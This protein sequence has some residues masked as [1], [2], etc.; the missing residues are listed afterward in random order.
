[1]KLKKARVTNFK[2]IIDSTDV[3]LDNI[4]C[5][6]GKNEA[7]K[8]A[9]LRALEG[10]RPINEQFTYSILD[11][12]PRQYRS[13][14]RSRYKDKDAQV[15][16][17][18]WE[19]EK[20][21]HLALAE[22]FGEEAIK[23]NE[24]ILSKNYNQSNYSGKIQIEHKA[25]LKYLCDRFNLTDI[26]AKVIEK[27]ETT[28]IAFDNLLKLKKPSA[29]QQKLLE[30]L[31]LY[32]ANCATLKAVD[33]LSQRVPYFIYISDYAI[34]SD[35]ISF[36]QIRH[37]IQGNINRSDQ[38]FLNLLE[39]GGTNIDELEQI[40]TSKELNA[41][42]ETI[43][44]VITSKVFGYWSLNNTLEFKLKVTT[45]WLNDPAPFGKGV[46]ACAYIVDKNNNIELILSERSAGFIWFFTILVRIAQY[47]EDTILLMDE[48]GLTI[49][50][51]AQKDL[52][53]YFEE[54]I[55]PKQQLVYTTHSPFMVPAN[56]FSR[57]RTVEFVETKEM[58]DGSVI[59][60]TRVS[61]G[62]S[63]G[64]STVNLPIL[65]ALGI[66]LTQNFFVGRN[67][68]L[69]EGASD[70]YYL[71]AFSKHLRTH[72]RQGLDPRWAICPIGGITKFSVFISLFKGNSLNT[73]VVAD[74]EP[75]QKQILDTLYKQMDGDKTRVILVTDIVG[76]READIEDLFEPKFYFKL[77]NDSY[78]FDEKKALGD[79][80]M[81]SNGRRITKIV[82]GHFD[83]ISL[84]YSHEKPSR[85][86]L[87]NAELLK[88]ETEEVSKTVNRFEILFTKVA[89]LIADTSI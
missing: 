30:H 44:D 66:E 5:L 47:G 52:L 9:F 50:G 1:M 72:N 69:V 80:H 68:L 45:G 26:E 37:D 76:K 59:E 33:I 67:T 85:Y 7:G 14:Y 79:I 46:I 16:V 32:R 17:T 83:S 75:K 18:V 73:V 11:D 22:E 62:I 49:H 2:S 35:K 19:L 56:D 36:N 81:G 4:T 8:T 60:G 25:V 48:P 61:Q 65:G 74:Y 77:V 24:V 63:A 64:A 87:S 12:Y 88:Q 40:S 31:K 43:S 38:I 34:M 39:L 29:A 3:E 6:I 41:R 20:S 53:L 58:S 15:I 86:L 78:G 89:N 57:V 84:N 54:I 28:K 23:S 82:Q 10:F 21:D 42:C 27:S 13:T 71:Q 51:A 70:L 55:G